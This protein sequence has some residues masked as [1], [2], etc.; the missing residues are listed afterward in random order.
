M[1]ISKG[2]AV[3]QASRDQIFSNPTHPYTQQLF[4][5][6]PVT[7]LDAIRARVARRKAAREAAAV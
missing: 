1:V 3:E 2:E 7:D 5:A 6:T 4:A